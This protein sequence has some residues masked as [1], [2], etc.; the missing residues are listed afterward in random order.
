MGQ[1]PTVL[2]QPPQRQASRPPTRATSGV[3]SDVGSCA[4][5]NDNE[6]TNAATSFRFQFRIQPGVSLR[7]NGLRYARN[8]YHLRARV[9]Q[10]HLARNQAN[11]GPEQQ[12][13]VPK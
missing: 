5:T 4:T 6:R 13:P 10:A 3:I 12:H 8:A 9:L 11:Q 2:R 1:S 7:L